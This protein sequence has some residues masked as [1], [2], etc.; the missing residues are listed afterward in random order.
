MS[1]HRGDK[2]P[3]TRPGIRIDASSRNIATS[4]RSRRGCKSVIE[5]PLIAGISK[6]CGVPREPY[7]HRNMK[8]HADGLGRHNRIPHEHTQ[9]NGP[10]KMNLH[11]PSYI[12]TP[13][14]RTLLPVF[15]ARLDM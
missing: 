13:H 1:R 10:P 7:T 9:G 5:P 4:K 14:N 12:A 3:R 8:Q 6:L 2:V 11:T 15:G